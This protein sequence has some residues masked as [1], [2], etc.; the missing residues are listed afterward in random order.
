M[1]MSPPGQLDWHRC[2]KVLHPVELGCTA[3]GA[4]LLHPVVVWASSYSTNHKF[5]RKLPTV[6]TFVWFWLMY[7]TFVCN[8][9]YLKYRSYSLSVGVFRVQLVT[10]HLI[11]LLN[12]VDNQHSSTWSGV[13]LADCDNNAME[14]GGQNAADQNGIYRD[15]APTCQVRI[16][17]FFFWDRCPPSPQ[18]QKEYQKTFQIEC[19]KGMS[20]KMWWGSL[21]A[22]VKNELR[23]Q[24]INM[25]CLRMFRY[26]SCWSV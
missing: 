13:D 21:E 5:Q 2:A 15:V 22:K 6:C 4:K 10:R 1:D 3:R 20:N 25:I 19:E 12:F 16:V 7:C 24:W 14:G 11:P 18:C 23:W 9:L 8:C 17:G 26:N